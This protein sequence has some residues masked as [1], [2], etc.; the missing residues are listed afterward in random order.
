MATEQE[1]LELQLAQDARLLVEA[2]S[3]IKNNADAYKIKFGN[4]PDNGN[5]DKIV[6]AARNI[7]AFVDNDGAASPGNYWNNLLSGMY[8][9]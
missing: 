6:R 7:K 9:V 5:T 8:V 3:R 1:R 4:P 2:L